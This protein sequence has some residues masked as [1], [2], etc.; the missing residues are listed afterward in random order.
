MAQAEASGLAEVREALV[1]L[2]FRLEDQPP[3]KG[4]LRP[5]MLARRG[6][7]SYIVEVKVQS[8]FRGP[9]FVGAVAHG[10]LALRALKAHGFR[11]KPLLAIRVE[12][13]KRN[14]A[15]VFQAFL[16]QHAPE[17]DWL[18][19]DAGGWRRWQI[20]RDQGEATGAA[21]E[22]GRSLDAHPMPVKSNPFAPRHQWMLKLLLLPGLDRKYWGGPAQPPDSVSALSAASGSA[23]SHAWNLVALL[24]RRGYLRHEGGRFRFPGLRRLLDDWCAHVRLRPDRSIGA[25]PVHSERS[26]EKSLSRILSGLSRP[27]HAVAE[28]QPGEVV[29]GGHRACEILGLGRSNIRVLRL[30]ADDLDAALNRLNLVPAEDGALLEVAQPKARESVFGACARAKGLPV[31]DALQLYLDLRLSPARGVEQSDFLF[32]RVL[33]PHFKAAGWL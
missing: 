4:A 27:A 19:V 1:S 10:I 2:G 5:D 3:G 6:A 28:A 22:R 23:R 32:E 18:I 11:G 25:A 17:F 8:A 24:D 33:A 29:I 20:G 21:R 26:A 9:Q 12:R 14:A 31:A 15:S 16:E 7:S 13:A 30:Y